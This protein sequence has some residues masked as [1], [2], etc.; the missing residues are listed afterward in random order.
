MLYNVYSSAQQ[1]TPENP[2]LILLHGRGSDEKDLFG[3]KENFDPR[4][5]IYSL[6]APHQF[7]WGGYT[8]FDLYEDGSVDE[9]SFVNSTNDIITFINSLET[10]KLILLGF[11]MGAIMS[12][13]IA[14]TKPNIC[15]GIAA[16]SGFAPVQMES[17]YHLQELNNLHIFISHGIHDPVIPISTARKTK[18]LLDRSNADVSYN[19]YDMA[20]QINDKCLND[21]SRWLKNRLDNSK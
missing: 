3:L 7:E 17:N 5:T 9:K 19:E 2:T 16:L 13:S 12:Y 11:S 6:R 18:E 8:W 14:L 4:L 21:V 15:T 10:K 20:H 1:Q